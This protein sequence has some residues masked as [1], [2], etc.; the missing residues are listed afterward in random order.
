MR[1][2]VRERSSGPLAGAMA[3]AV[4][5]GD[6]PNRAFGDVASI[7]LNLLHQAGRCI[8][9]DRRAAKAYIDRAAAL[10]EQ[11]EGRDWSANRTVLAMK[12]PILAPWQ[13]KRVA[14]F[15]ARNLNS[16]LQTR[17][18]A[19]AIDLSV[20]YFSR[21]FKGSFGMTG[22]AYVIKRRMRRA[23][24][25]MLTTDEPLSQIALDCGLSDQAQFCKMFRREVGF[26][27][28]IWRR[29]H[30]AATVG[31]DPHHAFHIRVPI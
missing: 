28:A 10:L 5:G 27:P 9:E 24:E 17:D 19:A 6:D 29:D 4:A 23:Q 13:A 26:R 2:I 30:G 1:D 12:G 22:R 18:L 31:S 7:V 21:A 16:P 8:E 20:S 14:E 3:D 15:V 25:L 11:T